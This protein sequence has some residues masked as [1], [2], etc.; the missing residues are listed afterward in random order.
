MSEHEHRAPALAAGTIVVSAI[1]GAVAA[2][3]VV[4]AWQPMDAWLDR[5]HHSRTSLA[6]PD[7]AQ[8]ADG[9]RALQDEEAA[10]ISVVRAVNASVV[11]I[12][13]YQ[14]ETRVLSRST[15]SI[16]F[17]DD[18]LR[19]RAT[20]SAT[21]S[22]PR[23][24]Q[25]GGGTGFIISAD[26]LILTNRHVVDTENVEYRVL[27]A[28]GKSYTAR[29]VGRDA[30]NDVA[31]IQIDAPDLQPATIGD[32]DS[33]QIGQTVLAVGN[34]FSEF[35][36]SVTRGIISGVNR[37]V[38]AGDASGSSEIIEEAIQTDAAINPG[39]SGGPLINLRGEVI[40]MNTAVSQQGQS[41]GFAIP[42]NVAKRS[43]ES[44]RKHGRIVRTWLGVRYLTI[45]QELQE[46]NS[47]PVAEGALINTGTRSSDAAVI[48]GSPAARAGL[49]SGDIITRINDDVLT[50]RNSLPRVLSK[51]WPGDTI[52]ITFLRE[53][54][55]LEV[56]VVVEEFKEQ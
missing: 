9:L 40:G 13:V 10:T 24:V 22:T 27:L 46:M 19:S 7:P 42:I 49:R 32:S 20:S 43:M 51:Y 5:N 1:V 36:N 28:T 37:R 30:I 41:V 54:K 34:A 17:I 6:A 8:V 18:L 15:G 4:L 23:K 56:K 55:T 39:N 35:D 12:G 16:P 3:I 31:I 45:T 48:P 53:G 29:V 14:D 21:T 38:V 44:V 47:L 52:S 26:G 50:T 25:I 11:S 33:I 2:S